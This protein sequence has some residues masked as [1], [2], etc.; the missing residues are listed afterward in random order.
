M[1]VPL[2]VEF[3]AQI[4][5]TEMIVTAAGGLAEVVEGDIAAGEGVEVEEGQTLYRGVG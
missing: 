3:L 1:A 4:G 5:A 2:L